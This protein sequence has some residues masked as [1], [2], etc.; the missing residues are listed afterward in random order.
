MKRIQ[1]IAGFIAIVLVGVIAAVAVARLH[2]FKSSP[3]KP[4][5]RTVEIGTRFLVRVG[6]G[7]NISPPDTYGGGD[8]IPLI[9]FSNNGPAFMPGEV[10]AQDQRT[11]L[12]KI[13]CDFENPL[14][15][16]ESFK[17]GD[18]ALIIGQD[19]S[20]DFLAVGYD[21][22]LCAMSDED[23]KAV[24]GIVVEIP[25]KETRTLSFVFALTRE[26]SK[27]GSIV[28]GGSTPVPFQFNQP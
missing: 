24:K 12:I 7:T 3:L 14:E 1:I 13:V 25:A 28:I 2:Q 18:V 21:S 20:K 16:I 23:R 27:Q 19:R 4:S 6:G 9:S 11:K 10:H 15:Q 22:K 5:V 26:D 8:G 17:I